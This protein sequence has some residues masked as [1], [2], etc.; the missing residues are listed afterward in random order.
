MKARVK[1]K[2]RYSTITACS[3]MMFTKNAWRYLPSEFVEEAENN[4][5]LEVEEGD[6]ERGPVAGPPAQ[7]KVPAGAIDASGDPDAPLKE[8]KAPKIRV[9]PTARTLAEDAGLDLATIKGSGSN[10]M[11]VKG[12][13]LALLEE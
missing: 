12:D 3:G 10:G 13:V 8:V 9:S 11:I 6:A 5:F 7:P 2:A 4:A 1:E